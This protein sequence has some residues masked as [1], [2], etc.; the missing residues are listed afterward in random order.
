M[1]PSQRHHNASVLLLPQLLLLLLLLQQLLLLVCCCH[2]CQ[3]YSDNVLVF[4]LPRGHNI[5]DG[6]SH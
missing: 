1:V 5:R 6:S 4:I 3:Q 2:L